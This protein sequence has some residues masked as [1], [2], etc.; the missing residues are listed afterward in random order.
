M[1]TNIPWVEKYR[2]KN[3]N[4][5]L[6]PPIVNFIKD[7]MTNDFFPH[8]IFYGNAGTG[9]T[10]TILAVVNEYFPGE[11]SKYVLELNASDDR[12]ISVVRSQIKEFCQLQIINKPEMN[13]KYKLVI[14]DEADALTSDAQGALRRIIETYTFNTRFC[15]ICNYLSKLI[16]AILSRSLVIIFPKLSDKTMKDAIMNISKSEN[17]KLSS[18]QL[19]NIIF[20]SNG[21]L[22]KGINLLQNICLSDNYSSI[23]LQL[24][25]IVYIFDYIKNHTIKESYN[26]LIS[27]REKE[28]FSISELLHKLL[29]YI[30]EHHITNPKINACI[31]KL[32]QIEK[33]VLV[34]SIEKIHITAIIG[35]I[36]HFNLD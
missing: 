26:E 23:G 7:L 16:D 20:S 4:D 28:N 12:G 8:M 31:I 36:K 14:L 24:S 17:I 32:A 15:L 13:V 34:G 35:V 6:H 25:S 30:L 2:P 33:N 10:S 19:K 3:V 11:A 29:Q 9:K 21:D 22:R 27:I 1:Q 5:V 18:N